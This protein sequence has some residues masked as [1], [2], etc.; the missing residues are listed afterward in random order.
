[1]KSKVVVFVVLA[2]VAGT[3]GAAAS[4]RALYRIELRDG[5]EV[6]AK[7][8]P[9]QRGSLVLFHL[10]SSGVLTSLPEEQVVRVRGGVAG[11]SV[12][13]RSADKSVLY[14]SVDRN[15]VD[16]MVVAKKGLR[17]GDVVFL[18]PTGGGSPSTSSTASV[19]TA[20]P[21]PGGIY[22]PRS[23]AYGGYSAPRNGANIGAVSADT[24]PSVEPPTAENPIGSNGFPTTPNGAINPPGATGSTPL[25][26][27][28]NGTPVM[29]PAGAPGSVAPPNGPNGTPVLA[30]PGTPGA[31]SPPV[32]SNG[33]PA[34]KGPGR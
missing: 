7:D 10:K 24:F 13:Y 17:P 16:A 27:G 6:L 25:T 15:V 8:L 31:T 33:Y 30:Q 34:S 12:V 20:A 32:G 18:G 3:A 21:L 26:I 11:K 28:P 19:G 1:M 9:H 14:R 23:P 22:D 29:S 5:S 4:T 2:I